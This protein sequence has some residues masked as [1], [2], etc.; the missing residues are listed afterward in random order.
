MTHP[1]QSFVLGC[2][3]S[4]SFWLIPLLLITSLLLPPQVM[5]NQPDGLAPDDLTELSLEDLMN[6]EITSVSKKSETLSEAPAAIFVITQEDLRRS[7]ATTIADALRMVPGVQVGRIDSN[8]WAVSIRG[9]NGRFANKLLVLMDGRSVYT[10]LYSGVFWE[11]QDTLLEDIDRIEVIRGP[12]AALWGANAVNGVINIITKS[13]EETTGTLVSVGAGTEERANAS[14]RV[15]TEMGA[16][17]WLRVYAKY[18]DRD[19]QEFASGAAADDDWSTYRGGFRYDLTSDDLNRWTL[20]G[21]LYTSRMGETVA[22]PLPTVTPPF[23]TTALVET[24]TTNTGGNLLGRWTRSLR[25]DSELSFQAYYDRVQ[26]QSLFADATVDTVDLDFQHRFHF[27]PR[28]EIIWGVGYR[29]IQD[30]L[31]NGDRVF[32]EPESDQQNLASAFI[33]DQIT[34]IEDQLA[35]TLGAKLEHNDFTGYEFQPNIRMLWSPSNRQS[36]WA[37]VARAVRTPSRGEVDG[38]IISPTAGMAPTTATTTADSDLDSETVI[39]YEAGY[40]LQPIEPIVLDITA[41][42]NDYQHLRDALVGDPEFNPLTGQVAVPITIENESDA[43]VYGFETMVDARAA[44]WW[45]VSLAYT[46]LQLD[47]D[48]PD[49][50]AVP[51]LDEGG[52]PRHQISLRSMMDIGDQFEVDLWS[53]YVSELRT[54]D[55]D[56]YTTLDAQLTWKPRSDF[57]IA[58]VGQNL[59][60]DQHAEFVSEYLDTVPTEVERSFYAKLTWTY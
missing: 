17:Q 50:S 29:F 1:S 48:E 56:A 60:D 12:G 16:D 11:V 43:H 22:Q 52:S 6:I 36:I 18:T 49:N 7:G 42:Y 15:G 13:A 25:D 10:P 37:S 51:D 3:G 33:Q 31:D 4:P 35:L 8:K 45:R 44:S 38:R 21:D 53:R 14:A 24:D 5:A 28:Q 55:I 20:Q 58:L 2:F 32:V 26:F 41:F 40:R 59:I 27:S 46:Y 23:M 57:R 54:N 39:A 9:F 34:L 30:N 19:S 47:I